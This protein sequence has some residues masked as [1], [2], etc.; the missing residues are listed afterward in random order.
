MPDANDLVQKVWE[1]GR[2]VPSYD[3][4]AW[5]QDQCG[6]WMARNKYGNRQSKYGWE[7][8]HINPQSEGGRETLSNLRPL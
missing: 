8:D 1:K 2:I 3:P 5:R 6:A 7:I 4:T